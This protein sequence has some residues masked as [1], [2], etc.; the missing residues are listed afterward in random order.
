[1]PVRFINLIK[2]KD[3]LFDNRV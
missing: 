1:M 3:G 2:L